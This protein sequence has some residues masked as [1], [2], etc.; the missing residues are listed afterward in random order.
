MDEGPSIP[1]ILNGLAVAHGPLPQAH[2]PVQDLDFAVGFEQPQPIWLSDVWGGQWSPQAYSH[3][4][5]AQSGQSSTL[6]S[7]ASDSGPPTRPSHSTSDSY[8]PIDN[9]PLTRAVDAASSTS[10]YYQSSNATLQNTESE[11]S[12][13]GLSGE[14][15]PRDWLEKLAFFTGQI[16]ATESEAQAPPPS[17][18]SQPEIGRTA[19][20][21]RELSSSVPD[22]RAVVGEEVALVEEGMTKSAWSAFTFL[23]ASQ[24]SSLISTQ[25]IWACGRIPVPIADMDSP[26]VGTSNVTAA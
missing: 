17:L 23:I 18:S 8:L 25:F 7:Q 26:A 20:N 11:S 10:P 14:N 24:T 12:V 1:S 2:V 16:V 4:D 6:Y 15:L 9:S 3:N 22:R 19:R 13:L 21:L 5:S